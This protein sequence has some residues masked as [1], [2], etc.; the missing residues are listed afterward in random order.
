MRNSGGA[1]YI[2]LY[3]HLLYYVSIFLILFLHLFNFCC[4]STPLYTDLGYVL[5][6]SGPL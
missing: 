2:L 3:L 1:R 6:G 5:L 4:F